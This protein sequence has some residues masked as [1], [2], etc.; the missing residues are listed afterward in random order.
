[1][2]NMKSTLIYNNK[3]QFITGKYEENYCNQRKLSHHME[4]EM[5]EYYYNMGYRY[6]EYDLRLSSDGRIIATHAWEHIA[7]AV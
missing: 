1:M 6:F 7:V 3:F 5:F 4:Y 2:T